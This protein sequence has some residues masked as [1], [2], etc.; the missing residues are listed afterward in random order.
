MN[1]TKEE[2]NQCEQNLLKAMKTADIETLNQLLHDDLLFIIPTGETITKELDIANLESGSL[3]IDDITTNDQTIHLIDDCAIVS[4]IVNLKGS[5]L[6][7]QI[8]GKY[9]YIRTWKLFDQ[10]WQVIS[11]AGVHLQNN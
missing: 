5:F 1:S 9:K 10:N 3:Q 11:G 4:V 2:I 8:E 7:Q 6:K